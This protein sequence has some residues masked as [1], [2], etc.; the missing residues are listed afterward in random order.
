MDRNYWPLQ[1][2]S[3]TYIQRHLEMILHLNGLNW[4]QCNSALLNLLGNFNVDIQ[5]TIQVYLILGKAW[6]VQDWH[7]TVIVEMSQSKK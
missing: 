5:D 4:L 1:I 2:P 6:E 7:T 3:H